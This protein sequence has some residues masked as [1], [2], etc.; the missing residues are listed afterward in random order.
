MEYF[1]EKDSWFARGGEGPPQEG[2]FCFEDSALTDFQPLA[3]GEIF[4]ESVFC[5]YE[6]QYRGEEPE[7]K[8]P[9][10]RSRS[11]SFSRKAKQKKVAGRAAPFLRKREVRVK[12]SKPYNRRVRDQKLSSFIQSVEDNG[13]KTFLDHY[14]YGTVEEA[15][16]YAAET[17]FDESGLRLARRFASERLFK[18]ADLSPAQ[19][20]A[21]AKESDPEEFK[22]ILLELRPLMRHQKISNTT[23]ALFPKIAV[24]VC[25]VSGRC[26]SLRLPEHDQLRSK[27][28]VTILEKLGLTQ[29]FFE[30]LSSPKLREYILQQSRISF[31]AN[32]RIWAGKLLLAEDSVIR[33]GVIPSDF[34]LAIQSF[35]KLRGF[36][37]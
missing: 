30:A 31:L 17:S 13:L 35:L 8:S 3:S 33:M 5:G 9:L 34:D 2:F 6:S 24:Y 16:K 25:L 18:C 15:A 14:I 28:Y 37:S 12:I 20:E 22:K 4:D 10:L 1:F 11:S 21:L 26:E 32:Y 36:V 23:R 7:S 29:L 19:R 27:Q